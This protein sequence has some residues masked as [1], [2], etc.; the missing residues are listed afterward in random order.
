MLPNKRTILR[1]IVTGLILLM[2][3]GVA[4]AAGNQAADPAAEIA[5]ILSR[6]VK[7]KPA[8]AGPAPASRPQSARRRYH[9]P[10]RNRL[11]ARVALQRQQLVNSVSH[12]LQSAAFFHLSQWRSA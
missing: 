4:S 12:G 6:L 1:S 5:Q 8:P 11:H 3:N 7:I 9:Q 10:D 2:L